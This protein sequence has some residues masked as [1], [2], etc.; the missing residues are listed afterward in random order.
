MCL[1][2]IR[3]SVEVESTDTADS[4]TC[5]SASAHLPLRISEWEGTEYVPPVS[6][7]SIHVVYMHI[8]VHAHSHACM[9]HVDFTTS[10][11]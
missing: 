10:A 7:R 3:H 1:A 5:A 2:Y 11:C 9:D 6:S 4:S 8:C